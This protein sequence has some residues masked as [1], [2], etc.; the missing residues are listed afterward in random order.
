M[1]AIKGDLAGI[2]Q[3]IRDKKIVT[4]SSRENLKV[5]PTPEF[6]RGIYSVAG[7]HPAPTLE[8][9]AEAQYWVT[10]IDPKTPDAKAES[11]LHEYNNYTLKWLSMH[12]ALPG[13]YVQ[14]EHANDV[15]PSER[16]LLANLFA[17]APYVGG[18][19]EDIS[20][21]IHQAGQLSTKPQCRTFTVRTW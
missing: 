14:A 3:F 16:R 21:V 6:M 8:P 10:P 4:L 9:T 5:I 7:F 15:Q 12:E 17:N 1:D 13:H 18:S 19:A 20:V 11:K 2:T